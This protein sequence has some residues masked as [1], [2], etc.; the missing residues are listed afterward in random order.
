MRG[1][2]IPLDSGCA[3][4]APLASQVQVV[5][6]FAA[7]MALTDVVLIDVSIARRRTSSLQDKRHEQEYRQVSKA[8]KARWR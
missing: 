4:S 1:N 7:D 8:V 5:C 2:V 3:A 6:A